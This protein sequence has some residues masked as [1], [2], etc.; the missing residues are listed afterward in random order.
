MFVVRRGRHLEE[1]NLE[2][3]SSEKQRIEDLQRV[4]RKWNEDNNIRPQPRFFRLERTR[5]ALQTHKT[6]RLLTHRNLHTYTQTHT[7]TC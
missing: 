7:H 5:I 3:A 2:M 1:G 4:R 6:T